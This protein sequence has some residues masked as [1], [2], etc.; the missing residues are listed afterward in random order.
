GA[1]AVGLGIA[2]QPPLS[3]TAGA[4]LLGVALIA[5][6]VLHWRTR[7][8]LLNFVAILLLMVGIP[9]LRDFLFP[10]RGHLRILYGFAIAFGVGTLLLRIFRRSVSRFCRL[11]SELPIP[12][13]DER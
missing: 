10:G 5:L 6:P 13:R 3:F 9:M 1:I 7:S 8:G 12:P 2:L 4:A 11:D